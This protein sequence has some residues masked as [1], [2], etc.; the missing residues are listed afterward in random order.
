MGSGNF[1]V[2]PIRKDL[3]NDGGGKMKKTLNATS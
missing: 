1:R 3:E 2:S